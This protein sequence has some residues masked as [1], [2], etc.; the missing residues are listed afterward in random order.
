MEM[1]LVSIDKVKFPLRLGAEAREL[2]EIVKKIDSSMAKAVIIKATGEG[3]T[4][5]ELQNR[6]NGRL[7]YWRKEGWVPKEIAMCI[8]DDRQFAIY[9]RNRKG[10]R[11]VEGGGLENR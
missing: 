3:K 7:Q 2:L 5:R 9:W 8:T 4:M 1:K 6:I 11:V 10:G